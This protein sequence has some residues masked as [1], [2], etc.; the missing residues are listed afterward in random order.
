MADHLCQTEHPRRAASSFSVAIEKPWGLLLLTQPQG[1]GL[2]YPNGDPLSSYQAPT[3][4]I[5]SKTK[6]AFTNV[7]LFLADSGE[8]DTPNPEHGS[9]LQDLSVR[10]GRL[11]MVMPR[12]GCQPHPVF[13]IST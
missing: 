7:Q 11:I 2:G 1:I 5:N 4:R 10:W 13:S 9:V 12:S 6:M 3:C 8:A